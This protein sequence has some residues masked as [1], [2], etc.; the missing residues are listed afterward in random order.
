ME[1]AEKM[2][3]FSSIWLPVN[4]G[5]DFMGEVSFL[6]NGSSEDE[7]AGSSRWLAAQ[8]SLKALS[9]SGIPAEGGEGFSGFWEPGSLMWQEKK[10]PNIWNFVPNTAP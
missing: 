9:G 3:G 5:G 10:A 7:G 6:G 4:H 1:E 8:S 2:S